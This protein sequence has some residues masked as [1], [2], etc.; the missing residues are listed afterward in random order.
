VTSHVGSL[1]PRLID[2]V[3]GLD[4]A[5]P[6]VAGLLR[7]AAWYSPLRGEAQLELRLL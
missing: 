3:Y 2:A 5:V 6:A 1:R 4:V 7:L